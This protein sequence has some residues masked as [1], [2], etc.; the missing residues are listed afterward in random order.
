[1]NYNMMSKNIKNE[2]FVNN[3]LRLFPPLDQGSVASISTPAQNQ[4][5]LTVIALSSRPQPDHEHSPT[6][7]DD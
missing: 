7:I 1:M 6:P 2:H 3:N 4:P 5:T